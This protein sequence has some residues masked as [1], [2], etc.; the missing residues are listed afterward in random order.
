MV[1]LCKCSHHDLSAIPS[2]GDRCRGT[3]SDGPEAVLAEPSE[4]VKR[5]VGAG[6]WCSAHR[7]MSGNVYLFHVVSLIQRRKGTSPTFSLCTYCFLI[8]GGVCTLCTVC[9]CERCMRRWV[10]FRSCGE[11]LEFRLNVLWSVL[12][13]GERDPPE[14]FSWKVC[15]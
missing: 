12:Y 11:F 2:V 8:S 3:G 4:S 9:F 7:E 1:P 10:L 14:T 15:V 5:R 6:P 13:L